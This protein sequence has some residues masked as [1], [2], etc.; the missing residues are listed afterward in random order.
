[1]N[2]KFLKMALAGLVLS[3][4]GFANA[5]LI[6]GASGRRFRSIGRGCARKTTGR[7]VLPCFSF[8]LHTTDL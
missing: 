4:I 6:A 1:M 5:T 8:Q 2:N 3:V 7:H